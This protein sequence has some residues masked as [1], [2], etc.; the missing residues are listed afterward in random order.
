MDQGHIS[1][2]EVVR[3]LRES[4]YYHVGSST[5]QNF[6]MRST[7]QANFQIYLMKQLDKSIVE[8]N[9][10]TT[11]YSRVMTWLT[12]AILFLTVVQIVRMFW[13]NI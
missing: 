3:Q 13:V 11:F 2:N 8:F 4:P 12:I 10:K 5:G 7:A 1:E 6:Q 9:R